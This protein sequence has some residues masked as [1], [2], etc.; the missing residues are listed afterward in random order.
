MEEPD[1]SRQTETAVEEEQDGN[2]RVM[3]DMGTLKPLLRMMSRYQM[4]T[5]AKMTLTDGT[6]EAKKDEGSHAEPTRTSTLV[7]IQAAPSR[8]SLKAAESGGLTEYV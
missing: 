2:T 1:Q 3:S 5:L 6:L 8:I 7:W 4:L